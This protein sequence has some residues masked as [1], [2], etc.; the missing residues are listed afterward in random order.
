MEGKKLFLRP[1]DHFRYIYFFYSKLHSILENPLM[2]CAIWTEEKWE[3]RG[4]HTQKLSAKRI[5]DR[6]R[7]VKTFLLK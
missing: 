5:S 6:R 3:F 1:K 4:H 7:Q 2:T